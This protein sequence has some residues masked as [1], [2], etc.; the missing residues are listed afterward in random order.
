MS[1]TNLDWLFYSGL[2]TEGVNREIAADQQ[3]RDNK[4]PARTGDRAER[5]PKAGTAKPAPVTAAPTS[6]EATAETAASA[7]DATVD[8]SVASSEGSPEAAAN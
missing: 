1:D 2:D 6:S 7:P 5:A 8:A 4:K 3:R